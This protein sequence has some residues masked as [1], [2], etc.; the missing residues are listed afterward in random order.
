MPPSPI[1]TPSERSGLRSSDVSALRRMVGTLLSCVGVALLFS[2]L[3]DLGILWW[4]Q[5]QP[6][7]EWEFTSLATTVDQW[8]LVVIGI[9]GISAGL[10]LRRST[11]T[12]SERLVVLLCFISVTATGLIGVFLALDFFPVRQTLDQ[13]DRAQFYTMFTKSIVLT[14]IYT[15]ALGIAGFRGIRNRS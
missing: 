2:T 11:S 5:Y 7:P 6:D 10:Y 4:L 1:L 3:V 8:S 14:G 13:P 12:W 9:T 15:L